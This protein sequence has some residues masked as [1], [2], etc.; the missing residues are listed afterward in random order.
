LSSRKLAAIFKQRV[1]QDCLLLRSAPVTAEEQARLERDLQWS[2]EQAEHHS[3]LISDPR[4]R[5]EPQRRRQL[6]ATLWLWQQHAGDPLIT[7]R[8]DERAKLYLLAATK[9]LFGKAVRA[10]T[11]KDIIRRY[12]HQN[13]TAA[14]LGG[15]GTLSIDDSKVFV[16]SADGTVRR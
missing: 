16:I 10:P 15:Q 6:H 13:F 4:K 1:L 7:D 3:R 12:R 9:F 8:K 2:R 14:G 5:R 11:A